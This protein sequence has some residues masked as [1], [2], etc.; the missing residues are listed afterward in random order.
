MTTRPRRRTKVKRVN[1][2]RLVAGAVLVT[3]GFA[4]SWGM[5]V[6]WLVWG[7]R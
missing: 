2:E 3:V 4:F 1:L 5:L 7:C 6:A